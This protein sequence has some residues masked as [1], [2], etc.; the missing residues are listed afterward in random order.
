MNIQFL[1]IF[2]FAVINSHSITMLNMYPYI[3]DCYFLNNVISRSMSTSVF[4][5]TFYRLVSKV[6]YNSCFY[7][8]FQSIL[9]PPLY[10][11][12]SNSSF[13]K[14]SLLINQQGECTCNLIM[15]AFSSVVVR[16][17]IV[18]YIMVIQI[19]LVNCLFMSFV[20][21]PSYWILFYLH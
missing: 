8:G 21:F 14:N 1:L 3:L 4:N 5:I 12:I 7:Q 16:V 17:G 19:Y 11:P 13:K 9:L 2:L 6:C 18:S 10:I 20:H 15:F